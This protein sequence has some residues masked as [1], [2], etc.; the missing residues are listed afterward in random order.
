MFLSEDTLDDLL[1][2]AF[3]RL[4]NS[5]API[6][7][8]KGAN[9]ELTGISLHLRNPRARLSRT[10]TK[11][12]VFSCLGETL[13]YLA[14]S[15]ELK[16]I[17]Y[18][19][20][21]YHKFSDDGRTIY[22]A[23]GPRLFQKDGTTNQ[24]DN[25]AR[26]LKRKATTRQAVVQLY[27]GRDIIKKHNDIPCTCTLQFLIRRKRLHMF[28]YM[29]SNDAFKGLPHDVF[30]FTLLQELLARSI[31]V[32]LGEYWHAAASLHIYDKDIS[33]AKRYLR[34]GWRSTVPMP[35]MPLGDPWP[36]IAKLLAA[37]ANIREGKILN[38]DA[39]RLSAY[40]ADLARLL[41]I[42]HY[43]QHGLADQVRRLR[44][45]MQ[46]TAYDT[47]ITRRLALMEKNNKRRKS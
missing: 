41:K 6:R 36:S 1:H 23:Y 4:L 24:I 5:G 7:A 2:V 47:Y 26:L 29:R 16:F 25:V 8:S 27:D 40:W 35:P 22:G 33:K 17:S 43:S 9:I 39:I 20:K 11:G 19:L 34:E 28:T 21:D 45:R 13:W 3:E 12:T 37:E 30:A 10:E 38:A 15:N 44:S 14:A 31:G 46:S 18:Y 42:Y 32:R